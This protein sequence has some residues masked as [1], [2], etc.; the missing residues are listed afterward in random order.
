MQDLFVRVTPVVLIFIFRPIVEKEISIPDLIKE[1]N[2]YVT[3]DPLGNSGF[4]LT[5]H[6]SDSMSRWE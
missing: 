5:Y 4:Q 6:I 2:M 3:D 1:C